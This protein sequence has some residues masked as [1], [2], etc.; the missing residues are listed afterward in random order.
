MV[1][2]LLVVQRGQNFTFTLDPERVAL[3][4]GKRVVAE[5]VLQ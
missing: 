1:S 2:S 3:F 4:R 5:F